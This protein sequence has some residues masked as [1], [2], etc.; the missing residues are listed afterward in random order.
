M[1]KTS[2]SMFSIPKTIKPRR[3]LKFR[4]MLFVLYIIYG[5]LWYLNPEIFFAIFTIGMSA[6]LFTFFWMSDLVDTWVRNY[7]AWRENA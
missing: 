2:V 3:G 5:A 7:I 1:K 4:D 6:G